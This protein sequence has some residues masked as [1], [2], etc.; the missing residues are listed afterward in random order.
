MYIMSIPP[1]EL[2]SAAHRSAHPSSAVFISIMDLQGE[3]QHDNLLARRERTQTY[4]KGVFN[5]TLVPD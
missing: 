4:P 2:R 5:G 1:G 3:N